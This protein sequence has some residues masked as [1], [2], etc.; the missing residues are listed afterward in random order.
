G[1]LVPAKSSAISIESE[2]LEISA[3]RITVKYIFRNNTT[4]AVDGIVAFPLPAI[5]GGDAEHVPMSLPSNDPV[6]F[7]DFRI[8]AG[9]KAIQPS[10]ETRAFAKDRE[11]T[12]RLRALRI[13]VSVVDRGLSAAIQRVPARDRKQLTDE[14]VVVCEDHGCWATWES[15]VRFWWQ[16]HFP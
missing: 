5:N 8:T 9:G 12:K 14:D 16:Q 6:N 1:G 15:R 4:S 11:I 2:E 10:V 7:V 3:R 13:P